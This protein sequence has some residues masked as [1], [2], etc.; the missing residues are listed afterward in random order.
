M[1]DQRWTTLIERLGGYALPLTNSVSDVGA[2]L[3]VLD[4]DALILTGGNDLSMLPNA[5]DSAP[6]RDRFEAEA[7]CYFLQRGKP[8]LGVC[9]GAQ[10]INHL[11]GG[12]LVRVPGHAGT[13]HELV[14]T[15]TPPAYWDCPSE[16]NSYHNWAIPV[17]GLAPDMEALAWARDGTVEAF[18]AREAPVN[19]I[20]WHPEREPELDASA[21]KFLTAA[22]DLSPFR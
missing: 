9:R 16:V 2:Y 10:I 5:V 7:Y 19:A 8:V 18:H 11:A 6:E 15:D 22:L 3:D 4:L 13:R 14:W 21:L 17:D 20:V 1:L 12:R